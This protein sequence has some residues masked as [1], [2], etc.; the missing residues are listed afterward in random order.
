MDYNKIYNNLINKN[1]Y[2][3]KKIPI[4]LKDLYISRG[5]NIGKG[6]YFQNNKNIKGEA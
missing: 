2:E 3:T 6:K 4:E 1:P 5:W